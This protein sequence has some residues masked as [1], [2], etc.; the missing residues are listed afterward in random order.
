MK[1]IVFIL[2][3]VLILS[4]C[5]EE[6][7]PPV[8]NTGIPLI[9]K[10]LFDGTLYI[11]YTYT[12]AN[13]LFEEKTKL[14]YTK[15]N[16]NNQ[17]L[18]S[19]SEYYMDP[20]MYSSSSSV[21]EESMNREEWVNPDN[22]AKSLT[23][24]F[25]YDGSGQLTRKIYT[26]TSSTSSEYMEFTLESDRIIRQ[27]M[28]WEDKLS[29]YIDYEY[30]KKG[31]L[32]K[33]SRFYVPPSGPEELWTITEYEF[34]NMHNP[35]RA[36]RR[37]LSPGKYTNPNNITKQTYTIL[38]EVDQ[39]IEKVQITNTTYQYNDDGYP[40]KVNGSVEYIYR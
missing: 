40:V 9:S 14:H 34:D 21:V 13:L 16:Y 8:E 30:D 39:W 27:K 19:S 23:Q 12:G 15:Y 7:Q 31:N 36:F 35:Y 37:L 29:S 28:Y 6:K 18:L 1:K 24:K 20:G 10:V 33:E 32:I 22:T 11:E 3:S 38:F 5:E 2:F 26:R 4:S 17:N 25:E